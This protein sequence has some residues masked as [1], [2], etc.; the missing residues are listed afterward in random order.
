M[1]LTIL[2]MLSDLIPTYPSLNVASLTGFHIVHYTNTYTTLLIKAEYTHPKKI[3]QTY[4]QLLVYSYIFLH[5]LKAV[6][7]KGDMHILILSVYS[8]S[9]KYYSQLMDMA[10]SQYPINLGHGS[11]EKLSFGLFKYVLSQ[12]VTRLLWVLALM[13]YFKNSAAEFN[14]FRN[15]RENEY[16]TSVDF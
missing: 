1:N 13:H 10:T 8:L 3:C 11:Q 7:S 9:H 12:Q 6:F 16:H 14:Q 2:P 4:H 15:R 5:K